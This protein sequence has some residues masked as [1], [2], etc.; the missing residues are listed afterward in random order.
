MKTKSNLSKRPCIFLEDTRRDLKGM[1]RRQAFNSFSRPHRTAVY[2]SREEFSVFYSEYRIEVMGNN[3][4]WKSLGEESMTFKNGKFYGTFSLDLLYKALKVFKIDWPKSSTWISGLLSRNKTLW[5]MILKGK[6]TNPE[7]LAKKYSKMYFKG[8]YSYKALKT[9]FEDYKSIGSLW[10]IY[11]YTTNPSLWVEKFSTLRW[12]NDHQ[13]EEHLNLAVDILH[14]AKME[15]SKVNPTWSYT[16][17]NSEH[18]KQIERDNLSLINTY[19]DEKIATPF[20]REG[21]HLILDEREAFVEGTMMHNCVHSCYWN[22]I[23]NGNYLIAKGVVNGVKIDVGISLG[24]SDDG[25][26]LHL[27]QVHSIYNGIVSQEIKQY[28]LDWIDAHHQD[29]LGV[30]NE[31]RKPEL[32][33]R[34][35]SLDDLD[36]LAALRARLRGDMPAPEEIDLP[37]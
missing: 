11:Y 33:K 34:K 22:K 12:E 37:F 31:I 10:D 28:C 8:A 15:N 35:A 14:Y 26:A 32:P 2:G 25:D 17:M 20:E 21:L 16:R 7:Q 23:A 30:L 19:S 36:A 13:Y 27:N 1:S 6:I 4:F 3:I 29:L 9:Y 5:A 18:Q 24:Y